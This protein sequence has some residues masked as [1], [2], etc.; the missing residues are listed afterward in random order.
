LRALVRESLHDAAVQGV[1]LDGQFRSAYD[2]ARHLT[3]MVL[4]VG[5]WRAAGEAQHFTLFSALPLVMG[6]QVGEVANYLDGCRKKRN[7]SAYHR[8]GSIAHAEVTELQRRVLEFQQQVESWIAS[9][10][11][12]LTP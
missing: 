10:R 12:D 3:A 5:G 4:A 11:P 8:A 7:I 1:S 2:A 9:T 6:P